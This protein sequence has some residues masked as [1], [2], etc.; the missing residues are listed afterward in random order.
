MQILRN[1]TLLPIIFV[2]PLLQLILL[3]YAA[4]LEMKGIDMFIVD[5]DLSTSSRRLIQ[6][7][8]S[9]PF[10]Q[11]TNSSFSLEQGE[12]ELKKG[13]ADII[14][15]IPSGFE[16]DLQRRQGPKVQLIIDAIN[17]TAAGLINGY[18]NAIITGFNIEIIPEFFPV[19][20]I[21]PSATLDITYSLWYNPKMNYKIY[22]LPALMVILVTI[23]GMFLSALNMVREKELGTIE[24]IN[25]TPI[26]KYHFIIGKLV[27][28]WIIAMI[29]FGFLLLVGKLFFHLP[30]IGSIALL[31]LFAALY[32]IVAL[33][34][35]LF[36]STV[37]QTQQQVMFLTFFFVI[38]FVMMGGIFTPV[39]TMP[40]WAQKVNLIN[41]LSYFIRVVRMILLK[42]STFTDILPEF[43]ALVIYAVIIFSLSVWRYRKT[44]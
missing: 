30:T 18:T 17:G 23:I 29:E 22:M 41:P 16:N 24:Q 27:P 10:Y 32:L 43:K 36:L 15:H 34:A 38:V 21:R 26:R 12:H 9:S 31:Y 8:E 3:L 19:G 35:S 7:F 5:K 40:D 4:N 20:S 6:K 33:G 1:R 25:V 42:G 2:A 14:L 13:D 37:S 28:F 11:I 44:T 39:E